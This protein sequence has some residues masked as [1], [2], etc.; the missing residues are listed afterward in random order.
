[1]KAHDPP[2]LGDRFVGLT[3]GLRSLWDPLTFLQDMARRY[4]DMAHIQVGFIH[5]YVINHP[6]LIR[7]ILITKGKVSASGS[8]RRGMMQ[9]DGPLP[10]QRFNGSTA[11]NRGYVSALSQ[12][13]Y[14]L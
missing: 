5:S 13:S 10:G 14:R 7:E 1:M 4:G 9:R 11:D 8:G 3:I 12:T 2:G 6:S